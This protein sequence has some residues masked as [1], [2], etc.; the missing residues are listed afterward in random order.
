MILVVLFSGRSVSAQG[1]TSEGE[2]FCSE[3][4]RSFDIFFNCIFSNEI[5]AF[6]NQRETTKQVE[7]TS[8]AETTTS[9]VDQTGA[10]DLMGLALNFIGQ[11]TK[12]DSGNGTSGTL[13]FSAYSLAAALSQK[14]VLDPTFYNANRNLRRLSFTVGRDEAD[15][16]NPESKPATILGGKILIINGRDASKKKNRDELAK[17]SAALRTASTDLA[18]AALETQVYLYNVYAAKNQMPSYEETQRNIRQ[19]QNLQEK[20]E[21]QEQFVED[22]N[23]IFSGDTFRSLVTG[24]TQEQQKKIRGFLI[25]YVAD[26]ADFQATQSAVFEKIRRAPQLSFTF[27]SKLRSRNNPDEYRAGLLFDYG[28]ANRLNFTI[29]GTYDYKNSRI[30]GGDQRGGRLAAESNFQLTPNKTLAGAKN[31]FLFSLAAEGKWM[32]AVKPTYTGQAKLTI[33]LYDG[34]NFPISISYGNRP[35]LVRGN[36]IRGN[37]GFTFDLGKLLSERQKP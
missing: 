31:P 18:N 28:I 11:Q 34:I 2:K 24:L 27:Q 22:L 15:K 33:P 26:S 9:L 8:I 25:K 23:K 17:V 3:H 6:L 36:Y 13:T 32:N 20:A 21:K 1:D 12:I 35:D 10:P 5:T 14:D 37:F 30:I 4:T 19:I 7:V 16:A 29:N